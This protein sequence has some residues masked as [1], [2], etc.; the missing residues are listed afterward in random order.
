[1]YQEKI[2]LEKLSGKNYYGQIIHNSKTLF[3]CKQLISPYIVA[4]LC[5]FIT[6]ASFIINDVEPN[7]DELC[8]TVK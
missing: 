7:E 4:V 1:M 2:I 5:T 8:S 3:F 6:I